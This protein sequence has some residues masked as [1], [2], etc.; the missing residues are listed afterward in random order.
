MIQIDDKIVS[1]DL[2]KVKFCCNIAHCKGICCVEGNS[3][4]PLEMDE[5]DILEQEWNSYKPYMTDAGIK[6]IEDQ[7]FMVVDTDGDYTTPLIDDRECAY[8][9]EEEGVTFCAIE[10]ACRE[11]KTNFLKPISCHLYPIRLTTFSNGSIGL[12]YHRWGVCS[13]ALSL[14]DKVGTPVYRSLKEPIIRRFGEEF[15]NTL[16]EAEILLEKEERL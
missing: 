6:S 9:F 1:I 7:G 16:T 8:S 2:L 10:R 13:G 11:G 14:G 3:G 15:Y 5:V 4:A 12:N